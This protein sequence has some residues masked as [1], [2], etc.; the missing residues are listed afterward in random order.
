MATIQV[1]INSVDK[2]SLVDWASLQIIQQLTLQPDTAQ[3]M[4][5]NVPS[6]TYRPSLNDDVKIYKD[7]SLIF[8][9]V[10]MN[11]SETVDGLL[12][13]FTVYCKDYTEMLDGA[14]CVASY[15]AQTVSY[16]INDL[17]TNFSPG[18]ITMANVQ[19]T[20]TVNAAEFNYISLSQ[21]LTQLANAIPGYDWFIDYNK[22]IH[23]F[24]PSTNPAPFQI[25]DTSGNLLPLSLQFNAD[26]SQ[27]KNQVVVRG[28]TVTGS[29]VANAQVSDGQQIIFYVGYN[30]TTFVAQHAVAALPTTFTTLN[31]GQDG[32][33]NPASFDC[34]YNPNL[35]LLRFPTAYPIGDVVQ[36]SG[37]PQFPLLTIL[38]DPVSLATYGQKEFL[39]YDK[40][41]INKQ[42]SID[43]AN[44]ELLSYSQPNYTGQFTTLIAGLI[45]GQ[46]LTVNV[47]S[48]GLS[49]QFKIQQINIT[50]RTPSAV[51]S[52]LVYVVQFCS[53][54]NLD[55]VDVLNRL[56]VSDV[57]AQLQV[58]ANEVPD[59][60]Y[61]VNET[62]TTSD[63][64]VST[65]IHNP[66]NETITTAESFTAQS[67]GYAVIFVAGPQAPSGFKRV[68]VLNGS[69]LG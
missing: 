12:K 45:C 65:L 29:S 9:G 25:D 24:I 66:Q 23:F 22:D 31:V 44:A 68:F 46:Y 27:L 36:T 63:M 19:G 30:L 53:T 26:I 8:G 54:P 50:L 13:Y 35:G 37:I 15:T 43:R 1:K 7:G 34:L 48:R 4:I 14:L 20:Y 56:L 58:G 6:K 49:G 18:G 62:I 57:S 11:T 41:I 3:F 39:I 17:L 69:R 51:T 67:L 32:K 2:S 38:T 10:V 47:P 40:T 5:R 52:D 16:I 21:A 55:L 61:G 42:Q 28:G 33:D 60:V 59:R 64:I